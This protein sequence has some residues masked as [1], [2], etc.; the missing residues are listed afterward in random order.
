MIVR[1]AVGQYY[2]QLGT[3]FLPQQFIGGVA[4][5]GAGIP[6]SERERVFVPFYRVNGETKGSGLGMTLVR[7]IAQLH[8]GNVSVMPFRDRGSCI[9][10]TLPMSEGDA[11]PVT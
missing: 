10:V 8:G 2:E 6:E 1:P 4:D 7:G 3:R 5:G 11:P 9:R